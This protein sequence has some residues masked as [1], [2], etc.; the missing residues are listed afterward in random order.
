MLAQFW[1][2]SKHVAKLLQIK[3]KKRLDNNKI[4]I[5]CHQNKVVYEAAVRG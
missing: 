4:V 5:Q 2:G 1:E 3:K